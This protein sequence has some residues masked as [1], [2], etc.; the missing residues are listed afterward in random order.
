MI[1]I[2]KDKELGRWKVTK[3]EFG[4]KLWTIQNITRDGALRYVQRNCTGEKVC[5]DFFIKGEK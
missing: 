1:H 4:Q 2:S 5:D 3:T